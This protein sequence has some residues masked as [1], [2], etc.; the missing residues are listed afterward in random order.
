MVVISILRGC[1]TIE[2]LRVVRINTSSNNYRKGKKILILQSDIL[3]GCGQV[4]VW[5]Q[6]IN[7]NNNCQGRSQ[8]DPGGREERGRQEE[9]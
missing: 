2:Q 4:L 1:E 6:I 5:S 8:K 9:E 3:P 7:N